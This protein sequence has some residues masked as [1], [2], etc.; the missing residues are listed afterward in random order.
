MSARSLAL[1]LREI[2]VALWSRDTIRDAA[3]A[4]EPKPWPPPDDVERVLAWDPVSP[5]GGGWVDVLKTRSGPWRA[6]NFT[7][8]L[9]WPGDPGGGP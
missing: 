6:E 3:E 4:L 8:W 1:A 7:A 5:F 2:P 9:P